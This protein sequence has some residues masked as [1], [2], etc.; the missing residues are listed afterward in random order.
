M[1]LASCLDVP[2]S[3]ISGLD[4]LAGLNESLRLSVSS[5]GRAKLR[6]WA[7]LFGKGRLVTAI[8]H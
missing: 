3:G 6:D 2:Q 8:T 7:V 4:R 5:G 1:L